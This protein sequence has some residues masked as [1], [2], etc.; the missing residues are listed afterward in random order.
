MHQPT[1]NPPPKPALFPRI[2]KW[3]QGFFQALEKL[4]RRGSKGWKGGAGCAE[5]VDAPQEEEAAFYNAGG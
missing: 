4:A 2:G 3:K 1:P 5:S